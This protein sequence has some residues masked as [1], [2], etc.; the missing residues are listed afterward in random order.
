LKSATG[1]LGQLVKLIRGLSW[2]NILTAFLALGL[3]GKVGEL[4][5]TPA[6]TLVTWGGEE[7]GVLD[8]KYERLAN[9]LE[10]LLPG[11]PIQSLRQELG[12]ETS[13]AVLRRDKDLGEDLVSQPLISSYIFLHDLYAVRALVNQDDVVQ[14]LAVYS[15]NKKMRIRAPFDNCNEVRLDTAIDTLAGAGSTILSKVASVPTTAAPNSPDVWEQVCKPIVTNST[16]WSE[17]AHLAMQAHGTYWTSGYDY[18]I[19]FGGYGA[20]NNQV[21]MIGDNSELKF[22][23]GTEGIDIPLE[24]FP[25]GMV[26]TP[27][28]S[29]PCNGDAAEWMGPWGD[30]DLAKFIRFAE[31]SESR[32]HAF[33]IT[34]PSA[35]SGLESAGFG[36]FPRSLTRRMR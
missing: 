23:T 8:T 1:H 5:W 30:R 22:D 31:K 28:P 7:I 11:Q 18:A 32:I 29:D 36:P 4:V 33:A 9:K 16:R 13:R 3:V 6:G 2:K 17:V 26:A 25:D 27:L 34:A 35:C 14:V 15:L 10:A 12:P 19:A 20:F 24:A 21:M